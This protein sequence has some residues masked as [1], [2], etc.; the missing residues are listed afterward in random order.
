MNG[1]YSYRGDGRISA[2]GTDLTHTC[3]LTEAFESRNTQLGIHFTIPSS[4]TEHPLI[5]PYFL[6]CFRPSRD[7]VS[8]CWKF[9]KQQHWGVGRC[10]TKKKRTE[11][12][13]KYT[14]IAPWKSCC[15]IQIMGTISRWRVL[16][17]LIWYFLTR[18]S[19]TIDWNSQIKLYAFL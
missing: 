19:E 13:Y 16:P 15:P 11:I 5:L 17:L 18:I 2:A 1:L 14:E 10:K 9:F 8:R 3:D 6:L 4:A 7:T 12:Y